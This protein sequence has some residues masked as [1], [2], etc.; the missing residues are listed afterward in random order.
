MKLI[1]SSSQLS[2]PQWKNFPSNSSSFYSQKLFFRSL[3]HHHHP[4]IMPLFLSLSFSLLPRKRCWELPKLFKI[5]KLDIELL[6]PL[7]ISSSSPF[8]QQYVCL[9]FCSISDLFQSLSLTLLL[10]LC[11]VYVACWAVCVSVCAYKAN[12]WRKSRSH[13]Q[14]TENTHH[15]N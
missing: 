8:A 6:R 11:H 13:R 4:L 14:R 10:G 7:F 9:A 12:K 3:H 2:R 15:K 5:N 1:S